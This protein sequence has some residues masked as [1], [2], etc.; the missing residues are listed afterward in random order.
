MPCIEVPCNIGDIVYRLTKDKKAV[1]PAFKVESIHV[2]A[3]YN[4]VG[5]KQYSYVNCSGVNFPCIMHTRICFDDF[6]ETAFFSL[7]EAKA[8]IKSL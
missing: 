1:C 2:A 8:H 7:E 3:E 6:G 5:K 4:S